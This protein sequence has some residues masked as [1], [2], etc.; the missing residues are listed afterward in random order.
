MLPVISIQWFSLQAGV[1][2]TFGTDE[3]ELSRVLASRSFAQLRATFDEYQ[4]QYGKDIEQSIR[5]ETSG[6]FENAL[7]TIGKQGTSY[8]LFVKFTI[9]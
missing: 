4:K 8:P 2:K 5:S 7:A 9:V 3:N 1:G 6:D